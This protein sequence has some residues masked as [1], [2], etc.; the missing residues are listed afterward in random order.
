MSCSGGW[1][2]VAECY[3]W[4]PKQAKKLF[5]S[6]THALDVR[7]YHVRECGQV[8]MMDRVP[9]CLFEVVLQS[10]E[11]IVRPGGNGQSFGLC[12]STEGGV[13]WRQE[14]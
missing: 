14:Q 2:G 11:G 13:C 3:A 1:G 10:G 12:L 5:S 9:L 7:K 6:S 8:L 4:D